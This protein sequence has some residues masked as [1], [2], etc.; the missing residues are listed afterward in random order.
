[1]EKI[2]FQA[3]LEMLG[4]RFLMRLPDDVSQ[5]LKT[6]GFAM[7][8][9]RMAGLP[10]ILPLEPDG[11]GGHFLEISTEMISDNKFKVG[12]EV[13]VTLGPAASWPEPPL[14]AQMEG[15]IKAAGLQGT[16]DSLTTKA[17]WEWLRWMRSSNSQET[18]SKR[19]AVGMS[20]LQSGMRRPCC[21][22]A[23]SCTLPDISKGGV[24]M[25]P[26]AENRKKTNTKP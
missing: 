16:W 23:S 20:K 8:E 12:D 18:R 14:T 15:A 21:F 26:S 19:I 10:F 5:K 6:R 11:K 22:N 4:T 3:R 2:Q 24:L 7:A 1:M 25:A 17:R 9:G 13:L